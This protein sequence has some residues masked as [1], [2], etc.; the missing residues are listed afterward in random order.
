[1]KSIARVL[2]GFCFGW[3]VGYSLRS[4]EMAAAVC[5]GAAVIALALL[6]LR[7][8]VVVRNVVARDVVD[9]MVK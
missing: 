8:E 5:M 1:M 2:A 3:G 9:A 4:H 7:V 6:E